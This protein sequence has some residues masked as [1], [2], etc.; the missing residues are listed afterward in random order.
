MEEANVPI[1]VVVVQCMNTEELA[2]LLI[3]DNA[4]TKE[5]TGEQ[6]HKSRTRG[7]KWNREPDISPTLSSVSL[8]GGNGAGSKWWF[9]WLCWLAKFLGEGA[10]R[11]S[12]D[13][14]G[15]HYS[16]FPYEDS[17]LLELKYCG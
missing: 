8:F 15:T 13:G 2:Y 1:Q 6:N 5:E 16:V 11:F 9:Y 12:C 10:K 17:R 14:A 4:K 3:S 7:K